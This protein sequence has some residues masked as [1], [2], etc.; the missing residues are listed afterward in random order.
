MPHCI[1]ECYFPLY[2]D[3]ESYWFDIATSSEKARVEDVRVDAELGRGVIVV[4]DRYDD[5]L[6]ASISIF[7][8]RCD[9]R[10]SSVTLLPQEAGSYLGRV[11]HDGWIWYV[12]APPLPQKPARASRASGKQLPS[13]PAPPLSI[14]VR[15]LARLSESVKPPEASPQPPSKDAWTL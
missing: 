5:A 6:T 10:T 7:V 8:Q 14:A 2:A 4:R 11:R 13:P 9:A 15:K 12:F 3:Y 1:R